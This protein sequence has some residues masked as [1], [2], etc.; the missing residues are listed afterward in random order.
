[1]IYKAC[2]VHLRVHGEDILDEAFAFTVGVCA[3]IIYKIKSD[4]GFLLGVV[5]NS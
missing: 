1:M 5:S 4:K 3:Y 2:L